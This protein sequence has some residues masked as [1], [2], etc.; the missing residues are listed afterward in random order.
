MKTRKKAL[1]VALEAQYGK[2]AQLADAS[3]MVVSELDSSPYEGDR[4]TR[5]R[6]RQT[7]GAQAE[8]NAAPYA[9][10]TSTIPL[11]GSGAAGTAPNFG[12]LLRACGMSETLKAGTNV[13]YQP[14]TDDHESVTVWFIEDGQL[15]C[16]PGVRGT[17]ELSM[18]N[19]EYPSLAFTLTGLYQ[20]PVTHS[21]A[22]T[23][24]IGNI[25]DETVVNNYN[26]SAFKVHGYG[27][28]GQSLSLSLA[29]TV[30]PDMRIGKEEITITDRVSTGSV[31]FEAPPLAD[32][33]YFAALESHADITLGEVSIVHGRTAGNI[34]TFTAPKTQLSTLSRTDADGNV[35]YQMDARF[36][37]D[38]GD[39][40]FT[41][42]FS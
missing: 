14:V 32:K 37:P 18:T 12:L 13:V 9:S 15:Q 19:K 1:L 34:V 3:L 23:N 39:D 41:L 5:E 36:L 38:V 29:T 35:H 21:G 16:V 11:A 28:V 26:T 40:E 25:A 24:A 22:L 30:T 6:L 2:A 17:F 27:V 33:N 8:A 31:Q 42:A 20:R 4:V 7:F 10:V